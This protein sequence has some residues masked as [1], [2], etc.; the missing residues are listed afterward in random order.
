MN[1]NK[2]VEISGKV[3]VC[4]KSFGFIEKGQ[5]FYCIGVKE[6]HIYLFSPEYNFDFKININLLKNFYIY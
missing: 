1:S 4:N 3:I 5:K 2:L 6:D